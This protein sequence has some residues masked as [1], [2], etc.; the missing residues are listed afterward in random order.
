MSKIG[1]LTD[2]T[3]DL[4]EEFIESREYLFTIPLTL[5][6][7]DEQFIDGVDIESAE[8]FDKIRKEDIIPTTSQ[9]SAG[10]FIEKYKEMAEEYDQIISIHISGKLSGTVKSAQLASQDLD[11]VEI[12]IIDTGSASLGLGT[13]VKLAC[14]LVEAGKGYEEV[15]ETVQEY[16]NKSRVLFTVSD[17][18]F[19]E[20]GGRI[21][22]AQSFLGSI[23]NFHPLLELKAVEGE[24]SPNGRARGKKRVKDA[25]VEYCREQLQD[26]K[27]AWIGIMHGDNSERAEE[28]KVALKELCQEIGVEVEIIE[29]IISP[30]LGA[31]VGPSVYGMALLSGDLLK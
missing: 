27:Y 5:H 19:L 17:L 29:N 25:I 23:L 9:P 1:I 3:N 16:L 4:P 6:F 12:K 24:I 20:K 26:E 31:H 13:L 21:G 22:K 30:I 8:F 11:N 10:K 28:I 14:K 15:A 2:S 18:K 7:G